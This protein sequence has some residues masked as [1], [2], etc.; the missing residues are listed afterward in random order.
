MGK[1]KTKRREGKVTRL[2]ENPE[3]FFEKSG[4][5]QH[6]KQTPSGKKYT[7]NISAKTKN[8]ELLAES[9]DNNDLT[10]AIGKPGTGKTFLSTI[11]GVEALEC[12]DYD[13]LVVT[14]PVVEVGEKLGYLPGD[15]KDKVDPHFQPIYDAICERMPKKR[16]EALINDGRIEIAPIAYMRGRTFSNSFI[17]VDEAQNCNFMQLK[18]IYTRLGLNSKMI[19]TGDPKQSDIPDSG[20]EEFVNRLDRGIPGIG[21]VELQAEDIVR[22]PL[23]KAT[24]EFLE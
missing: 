1:P 18:T 14:T 11:K 9:I 5:P 15:L 24:L 13:K 3:D 2:F 20:L 17:I 23:L 4:R 6:P 21:K 22:H 7:K 12:G 8:Q 10:F 16:M 19:F